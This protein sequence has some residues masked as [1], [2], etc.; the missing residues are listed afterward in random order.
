MPAYGTDLELIDSDD[1]VDG[2][3]MEAVPRQN[4]IQFTGTPQ[5][6]IDLLNGLMS[7]SDINFITQGRDV[8]LKWRRII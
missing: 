5:D 4:H 6:S 1:G 2:V 3:E 7:M 8:P